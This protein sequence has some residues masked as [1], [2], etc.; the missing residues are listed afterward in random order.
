[1]SIKHAGYETTVS[2][3]IDQA[4]YDRLIKVA[5]AYKMSPD[6]ILEQLVEL[7]YGLD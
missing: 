5:D 2:T 7:W 1:M 3:L 6:Y 4:V